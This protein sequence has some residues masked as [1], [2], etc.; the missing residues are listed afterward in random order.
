MNTKI[1]DV[2][3]LG[4]GF[5]ALYS[6]YYYRKK[7]LSV[8]LLLDR[9]PLGGA[10]R[11]F[12]WENLTVDLG[13]HNL[14]L[15][16]KS[17]RD[18]YKE[19]LGKDLISW[20]KSDFASFNGI[21]FTNGIECP[22]LEGVTGFD[23]GTLNSSIAAHKNAKMPAKNFKDLIGSRFGYPVSD[24][25]EKQAR[26]FTSADLNKLSPRCIESLSFLSRVFFRSDKVMERQK[27]SKPY[28][29]EA[30]A[31]SAFSKKK[32]FLGSNAHGKTFGYPKGGLLTFCRKFEDYLKKNKITLISGKVLKCR[33][34]DQ[35][36]KIELENEIICSD[37]IYSTIPIRQTYEMFVGEKYND[38]RNIGGTILVAYRIK[39]A[40]LGQGI[41]YEY[42]HDFSSDAQFF[43]VGAVSI[44]A[45]KRAEGIVCVEIPFDP[46]KS[47]SKS[48]EINPER[49]WKRVKDLKFVKAYSSYCDFKILKHGRT[50]TFLT[51][52]E[53]REDRKLQ[54]RLED[55]KI[56]TIPSL[57]RG[58]EAFIDHF[59]INQFPKD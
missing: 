31:V 3:V 28:Y 11:S 58:R 47:S 41:G 42:I 44:K 35:L 22:D 57:L 20:E 32:E 37:H 52:K 7:G 29:N 24:Y 30:Y 59:K 38:Y 34:M 33:I 46:K 19:I 4:N 51:V 56:D 6:A 27:L 36:K 8:A 23:L 17:S 15:R 53:E 1:F 55:R 12:Q 43:R 5:N 16:R 21:K 45:E 14:D 25:I 18:F 2:I 10:M 48:H 50:H 9:K 49:I 39:G 40:N 26:R 13:V 54:D